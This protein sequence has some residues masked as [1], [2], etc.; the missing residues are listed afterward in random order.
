M[1]QILVVFLIFLNISNFLINNFDNAIITL[2]L[3]DSNK[4]LS[5][6]LNVIVK[7]LLNKDTDITSTK[8]KYPFLFQY[9]DDKALKLLRTGEY[10]YDYVDENL[11]NKLK[12][13]ELPDIKY[14]HSS[15]ANTKCSSGNYSYA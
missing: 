8:N 3:I 4:H 5:S 9:F 10:P 1:I 14:F 15:L 6:T 11:K 13:K 12:G 2:R 7:S